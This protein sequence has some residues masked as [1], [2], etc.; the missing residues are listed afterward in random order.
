VSEYSFFLV[1]TQAAWIASV[2]TSEDGSSTQAPNIERK[3]F[4]NATA[5]ERT[6]KLGVVPNVGC[7]VSLSHREGSNLLGDVSTCF[8][9]VE[10]QNCPIEQAMELYANRDFFNDI[11]AMGETKLH[12]RVKCTTPHTD[13][14][15]FREEMVVWF[16]FSLLPADIPAKKKFFKSS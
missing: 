12:L 16:R 10:G 15:D 6:S 13:E 8:A 5:D 14:K 4:F 1:R 11:S 9:L 2:E 7:Q 3:V